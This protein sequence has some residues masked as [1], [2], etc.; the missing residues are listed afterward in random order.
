MLRSPAV[1]TFAHTRTGNCKFEGLAADEDLLADATVFK[2]WK[3]RPDGLEKWADLKQYWRVN[4]AELGLQFGK[5]VATVDPKIPNKSCEYCHLS[6]L[7]RIDEK[8]Q[9]RRGFSGETDD[10]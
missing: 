5:G 6:T 8:S 1:V 9:S 3:N 2:E 7:C 4:L 10:E